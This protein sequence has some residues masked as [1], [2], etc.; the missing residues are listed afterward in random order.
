MKQYYE[1]NNHGYYGLVVIEV[2]ENQSSEVDF[3]KQAA[4]VYVEQIA[5]ES[6]QDVLE[7]GSPDL[8]T[9]EYAYWKFAQCDDIKEMTNR[10]ALAEFNG[11]KN[12]AIVIDGS[13]L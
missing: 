12:D 11:R 8:V 13:L 9:K 1:F 3:L 10:E 4:G 2:E 5:G 7:E 6:V